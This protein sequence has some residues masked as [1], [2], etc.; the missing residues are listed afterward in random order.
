MNTGHQTIRALSMVSAV[1]FFIGLGWT[2]T[3]A[4]STEGLKV[5]LS[6]DQEVPPVSTSASATGTITV[7]PDKSVSGAITV[8]GI[9]PIAAHIHEGAQGKNGPVIIPLTKG[10]DDTWSVSAGAKLTDAQYKSYLAK[11]LYINV[12]SAA[13]KGG[14]IRAQLSPK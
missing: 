10:S 12:H 14:E 2:M 6:G 7:S 11:D 1:T 3:M 8:S 5:N 4:A 9:E 13:H